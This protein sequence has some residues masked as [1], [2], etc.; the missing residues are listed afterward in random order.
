MFWWE[1]SGLFPYE[2][3]HSRDLGI[4]RRTI[5]KWILEKHDGVLW[6]QFIWLRIGTW[7]VLVNTV[8]NLWVPK[9]GSKFLS[10]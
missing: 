7:W 6:I 9:K 1:S 3:D 10:S 5:L 8:M 4:G 2:R